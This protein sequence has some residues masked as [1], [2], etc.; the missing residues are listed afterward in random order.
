MSAR[1]LDCLSNS[2]APL[3]F[4]LPADPLDGL[5]FKEESKVF[6][7]E[8][9]NKRPK[10]RKEGIAHRGLL[11][12]LS[13][14]YTWTFTRQCSDAWNRF[15]LS[16]LLFSRPYSHQAYLAESFRFNTKND[17]LLV[18]FKLSFCGLKVPV[19]NNDC[20]SESVTLRNTVFLK[21]ANIFSSSEEK[22]HPFWNPKIHYS[23]HKFATC[24][25][26][27]PDLSSP[28]PTTFYL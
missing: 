18:S 19:I 24:P 10:E 16:R 28:G 26:N 11:L 13:W 15:S 20:L 7:N 12:E 9:W 23:T 6:W 25:Y 17:R 5:L 27:D 14:L 8:S 22:P 4:F 1:W 3:S 21:R 2:L